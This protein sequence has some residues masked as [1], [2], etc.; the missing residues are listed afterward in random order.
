MLNIRIKKSIITN[1]RFLKYKIFTR[2][3]ISSI[4]IDYL[5]S[6]N[7]LFYIYYVL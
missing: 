1:Y 3:F 7:K 2:R 6:I 5:L 4:I